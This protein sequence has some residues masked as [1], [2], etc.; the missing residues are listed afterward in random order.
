APSAIAAPP[1]SDRRPTP[2]ARSRSSSRGGERYYARSVAPAWGAVRKSRASCAHPRRRATSAA[3]DAPGK[4]ESRLAAREP[5]LDRPTPVPDARFER[6]SIHA[7]EPPDEPSGPGDEGAKRGR[8]QSPGSP[9][10]AERVCVA[11]TDEVAADTV[12]HGEEPLGP[13]A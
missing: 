3:A 5:D 9:R 4:L 6:E 8:D 2:P 11:I 13:C 7:G 1:A 10:I 12:C